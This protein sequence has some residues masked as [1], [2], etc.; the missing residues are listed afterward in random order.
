MKKEEDFGKFLKQ[1]AADGRLSEA[2]LEQNKFVV[3]LSFKTL[4]LSRILSHAQLEK[5]VKLLFQ[6]LYH[7]AVFSAN[8]KSK[9]PKA[10]ELSHRHT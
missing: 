7:S 9:E 5:S 10:L 4:I 6:Y 3:R 8:Q 1:V 2:S